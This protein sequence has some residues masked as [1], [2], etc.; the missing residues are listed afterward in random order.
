VSSSWQWPAGSKVEMMPIDG[1]ELILDRSRVR[2]VSPHCLDVSWWQRHGAVKT[3]AAG[4][5]S[6][7]FIDVRGRHLVLRHYRRGGMARR[8]VADRYWWRGATRSRA[9][10]EWRLLFELRRAGLPVPVP[11]AAGYRRRGRWY[12]ADI[13]MEQISDA[14]TLAEHLQLMS[15]PL[16]QWVAIGRT[17]CEMHARNVWHADLNAHNVMLDVNGK[18]WLIDFDRAR[19]RRPGLWC[20]ANLARLFRS[21]EKV[22]LALPAERFT[23]AD[24]S[25]LLSGYFA[26]KRQVPGVLRITPTGY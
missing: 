1:G 26:A 22:M 8:L 19:R 7:A 21:I 5:G 2:S 9:F 10:A 18:V 3:A 23:R 16:A 12:T 17:V 11:L 25:A 24:W 20:D 13:L 14:R 4:R 15:L 6:T